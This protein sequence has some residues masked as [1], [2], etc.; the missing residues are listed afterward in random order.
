MYTTAVH[1]SCRY[2]DA[3]LDYEDA[4]RISYGFDESRRF[5]DALGPVAGV[6]GFSQGGAMAL[7][8][9]ALPGCGE[10]CAGFVCLELIEY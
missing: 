1:E 4:W 3:D 10:P 9:S 6:I 7:Q 2:G 5:V 8:V